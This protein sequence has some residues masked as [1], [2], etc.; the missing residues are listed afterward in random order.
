LGAGLSVHA[1]PACRAGNAFWLKRS[2]V[3]KV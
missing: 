1:P 3:L 2:R